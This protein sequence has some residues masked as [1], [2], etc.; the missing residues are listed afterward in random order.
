PYH[1]AE[2]ER[3]KKLVWWDE[4]RNAVKGEFPASPDVFHIHPVAMVGNFS[5]P[6]RLNIDKFVELYKQRHS[7]EFGWYDEK[8]KT[9]ISLPPLPQR[10]EENLR[11]LLHWINDLYI[12]IN[13][14]FSAKYVAYMLA[15]ARVE[16]YDW[17][18]KEFFGP[19]SEKISYEDAEYDYGCGDG[20]KNP[21]RAKKHG[22]TEIGDGYKYRG[23]GLVQITWK[24]NY[25]AFSSMVGED[26]VSNPDEALS[27]KSAARIMVAGMTNGT[28]TGYKLADFLDGANSDYISARKIING[29]DKNWIIA[30]Y[31]NH[32]YKLMEECT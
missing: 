13:Q 17:H 11:T 16:S 30:D 31:A 10:S 6:H 2:I 32:F 1:D 19:I 23:R 20:A 22:N 21:A 25:T 18:T 3:V 15:T 9:K 12:A 29:A 24:Q 5:C 28:F 26:L 7:G 14:D 8:T 27:W 4:V